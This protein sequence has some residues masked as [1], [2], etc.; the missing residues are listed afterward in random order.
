MRVED[1][2]M[3]ATGLVHGG[4]IATLADTS[5]GFGCYVFAPEVRHGDEISRGIH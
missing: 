4:S 2:H 5:I 1:I 3:A